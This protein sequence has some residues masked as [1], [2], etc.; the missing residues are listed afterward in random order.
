MRDTCGWTYLADYFLNACLH[1][2]VA[3]FIIYNLLFTEN[4]NE[5]R[6]VRDT[7][8]IKLQ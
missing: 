4:S 6:L 8:Y 7:Q 5:Y 3:G 2:V 1:V